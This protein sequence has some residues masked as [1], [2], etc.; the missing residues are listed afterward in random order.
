M[1]DKIAF[2]KWIQL[3]AASIEF[4]QNGESDPSQPTANIIVTLN[5]EKLHYHVRQIAP[6]SFILEATSHC[7]GSPLASFSDDE[8]TDRD[9]SEF[10]EA[11]CDPVFP[12]DNLSDILAEQFNDLKLSK[13]T[14]A[15]IAEWHEKQ[16][17]TARESALA[18]NIRAIVA[19]FMS[20]GNLSLRAWA[21]AFAAGL[22]AAEG[23]SMTEVARELKV[24]R[25]AVSKETNRWADLLNLPRS[26]YLKSEQAR[27]SYS[28]VQ[29]TNHWR[30]SPTRHV[31]K[32]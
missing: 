13:A 9:A 6:G 4:H 25:A 27:E 18:L 10:N 22:D 14:C 19:M 28:E 23:R 16:I 31:D 12:T 29:K 8:S 2:V 5:D 30:R 32:A 21:L 24:T 15:A 7:V 17:Q 1:I 20:P 3:P 11:S 26:R